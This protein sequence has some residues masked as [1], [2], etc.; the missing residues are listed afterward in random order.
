MLRIVFYE[1]KLAADY[2]RILPGRGGYFCGQAACA[3]RL[4]RGKLKGKPPGN[5][6]DIRLWAQFVEQAGLWLEAR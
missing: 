4:A 5:C 3:D 2:A 1:Q 6:Q